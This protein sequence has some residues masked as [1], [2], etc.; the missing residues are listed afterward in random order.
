MSHQTPAHIHRIPRVWLALLTVLALIATAMVWQVVRPAASQAAAVNESFAGATLSD[1][2]WQLLG[3][4]CLTDAPTGS[5]NACARDTDP[6]SST[7]AAGF[8]TPAAGNDGTGFLQLTDNALNRTGGIVYNSAIAANQG[9]AIEFTQYQYGPT[10]NRTDRRPADGIG[11][12][13]VDGS[14]NLTATGP[15][16]GAL[17]YGARKDSLPVRAGINNGYLGVGLDTF[18]NFANQ[19]HVGGTDCVAPGTEPAN[20]YGGSGWN[21]LD[22][23]NAQFTNNISLRGPGNGTTGYCLIQRQKLDTIGTA[24]SVADTFTGG[25]QTTVGSWGSRALWAGDLTTTPSQAAVLA[26]GRKIRIVV[27]P[28]TNPG[29]FPQ[30]TVSIDYTGTGNSYVQVLNTTAPAAIPAAGF[31]FG[32][33]ASTGNNT[34]SHLIGDLTILNAPSA[35]DDSVT[36]NQWN[37]ASFNAASLV[38]PGAS[39]IPAT[40]GYAIEDP[41]NPGSFG[42]TF[43]TAYGTWTI[44]P[45]TGATTYTPTAGVPQTGQTPTITFRATD[46][47]GQSATGTLEVIYVPVTG[48]L[49]K[50]VEPGATATFPQA[51]LGVGRGSGTITGDGTTPAYQLV[52]PTSGALVNTYTDTHGGVWTV[53][54]TT[55]QAQYA[56]DASYRGPVPSIDYRITDS[57]GE[58]ATGTLSIIMP[59]LAGDQTKAG[60]PGDSVSFDPL[61]DLVAAGSSPALTVSL[62]TPD[63]PGGTTQ[64][65]AGQGTWTL[66]T[67][68][69]EI[70][71]TPV[72]G[73]TGN[74]DPIN[75]CV[76]DGNNLSDTAT[77]TVTYNVPPT[78]GD[79][80]VT[81][82]PGTPATLNPVI[83]PGSDPTLTVSI[84]GSDPGSPTTKT[85]PGQGVWTI[86]PTTGVATF[87]PEPGYTGNP[88]PITYTVTDGNGLTDSGTLTVLTFTPPVAKDQSKTTEPSTPVTFDPIANLITP[89]SNPT[90]TV[91]FIDP[92]TGNPTTDLSVTVPG[93]GV[94]SIDPATGKVTFTPEDGFTG[95]ATI[96]YRV[97]DGN[98]LFDEANLTVTVTDSKDESSEDDGDDTEDTDDTD[99]GSGNNGDDQLPTTGADITAGLVGATGMLLLGAGLVIITRRR[100]Q[101]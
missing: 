79:Q 36:L 53:N 41:A 40:G 56:A 83:T 84:D 5:A 47:V 74:P 70:T 14:A 10:R 42:T 13:L 71:F 23:A 1:A 28:V 8:G 7:S 97:T 76:T 51:E 86:N 60:N 80:T 94:W 93:E 11:F 57:N 26:A 92:A 6:T 58:Q 29:D 91:Q 50:I 54:P 21:T 69:G 31:K 37:A 88:T 19:G 17:G 59:P 22:N 72:A 34:G 3:T 64:T 35:I 87:T 82:N 16:G 96:G 78:A 99:S 89:G 2:A 48:D 95:K 45:N 63:T 32:F 49:E 18:G 73:F 9:L 65:V 81:V 27:S 61:A 38:T 85:V 67:T 75:Y 4:A 20:L 30:V 33:A 55:G 62:V 77:L 90:L 66:N 98:T 25:A 101:S 24:G 12:F 39:P 52:H 15:E 68:T 43:T 100:T 44:N 46:G